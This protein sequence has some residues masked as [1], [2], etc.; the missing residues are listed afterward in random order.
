[1]LHGNALRLSS[2]A[3]FT[4]KRYCGVITEVLTVGLGTVTLQ[5]SKPLGMGCSPLLCS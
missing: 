1:M 5:T 4:L 2:I 3:N